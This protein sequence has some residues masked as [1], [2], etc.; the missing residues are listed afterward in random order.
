V[1]GIIRREIWLPSLQPSLTSASG[2]FGQPS[3]A[4]LPT[5]LPKS[6]FPT[7]A[8]SQSKLLVSVLMCLSKNELPTFVNLLVINAPRCDGCN[9]Q[10]CDLHHVQFSGVTEGSQLPHT[11]Q[12]YSSTNE[13]LQEPNNLF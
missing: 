9:A 6:R 5:E 2:K 3:V 11:R 8:N 12:A 7:T 10:T 4:H 1:L 13:L